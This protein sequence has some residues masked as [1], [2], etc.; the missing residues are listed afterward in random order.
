MSKK[1]KEP[2]IMFWT[3]IIMFLFNGLISLLKTKS[4]D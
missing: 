1:R 3:L 2:S 4:D